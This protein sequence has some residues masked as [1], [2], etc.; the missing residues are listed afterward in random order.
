MTARRLLLASLFG[1][2]MGYLEAAVVVYLR[3]LY[4]PGGFEFPLVQMPVFVVLVEMGRELATLLMLWA[5]AMLA[6]RTGRERFAWFS[7]LFG[8]WDIVYYV[9]LYLLLRWPPDLATPDLLF[10]I[11]PGPW[12]IQPVWVPVVISGVMILAGAWLFAA[13]ERRRTR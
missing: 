13:P 7:F 6:G 10:L 9:A 3:R 11:P 12:W 8:V 1:V 4:Y 2:A 5:V